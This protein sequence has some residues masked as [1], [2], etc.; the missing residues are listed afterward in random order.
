[1]LELIGLG[2]AA[3]A[4]SPAVA[5]FVGGTIA[6]AV[7]TTEAVDGVCM[8]RSRRFCCPIW[9]FGDRL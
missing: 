8:G 5:A 3:A 9:T 1:V 2:G 7:A 6:D 4:A